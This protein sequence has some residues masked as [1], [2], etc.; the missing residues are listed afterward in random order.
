MLSQD[1]ILEPLQLELEEYDDLFVDIP[2]KVTETTRTTSF[3]SADAS[4]CYGHDR[5]VDVIEL[6]GGS[7][8]VSKAAFSIGIG[9]RGKL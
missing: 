7:G 6:C 8:G 1:M 4:L 9:L 2:A 5:Y 3:Y